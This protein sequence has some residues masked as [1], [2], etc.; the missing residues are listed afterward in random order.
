MGHEERLDPD[1]AARVRRG[2]SR[3]PRRLHR[4][5]GATASDARVQGGRQEGELR[6]DRRR[7]PR[8]RLHTHERLGDGGARDQLRGNHPLAPRPR[9]HGRARRRRARLRHARRLPRRPRPTSARSSAATATASR[10]DA[11]R[12]TARRTRS[13]STTSPTR[14]TAGSKGFDKVVWRAESFKKPEGVGVVFTYTSPDGEEGYP[15]K[16]DGHRDL[17]ARPT[18]TS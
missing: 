4:A 18:T 7:R 14:C 1:P 12:W 9:P 16:L 13:P 11:S 17:H 8:G 6:Q 15:G 2:A 10:R 3:R 5:R